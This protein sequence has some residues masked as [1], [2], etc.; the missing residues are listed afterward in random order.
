MH[1]QPRALV[2]GEYITRAFAA[3]SSERAEALIV[4]PLFIG[5]LRQGEWIAD[6]AVQHRLPT[7]SDGPQFAEAGGLLFYGPELPA[8]FRRA[9]AFVDKLLKG[10]KPGD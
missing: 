2:S 7:V 3:M 8:L 4:Q 9:A 5:A 6:L 10:A 1:F